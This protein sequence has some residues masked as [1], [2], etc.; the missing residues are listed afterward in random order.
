LSVMPKLKHGS[1]VDTILAIGLTGG[2]ATG[3]STVC[4][5]LTDLG[6]PVIDSDSLAHQAME[7]GTAGYETI[8]SRFGREI[9][10]PDGTVDRKALG[11]I[12][13]ADPA[14][15]QALEQIIH[16]LVIAEIEG[17]LQAARERGERLVVVEVPLLFEAG[18]AGL[19]DQVWVVST[20][21]AVQRERLHHRNG[22]TAEHAERRI[23]AQIPLSDKEG[24]ADRIINNNKGFSELKSEVLKALQSL[25]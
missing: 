2:I 11:A 5:I 22:F 6:I 24:K 23:A 25:E 7:P 10:H 12:V 20:A 15:R 16:P 17:R 21:A 19:F 13:F 8:V 4:R 18:M 3:K 9:L 14:A 1:E